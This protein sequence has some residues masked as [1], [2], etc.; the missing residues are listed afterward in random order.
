MH[1][2]RW[3]VMLQMLVQ[4]SDVAACHAM[5]QL[6]DVCCMSSYVAVAVTT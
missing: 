2:A 5:W 3:H 1:I 6:S 4:L